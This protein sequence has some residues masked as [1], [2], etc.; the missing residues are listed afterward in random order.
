M[1]EIP[2]YS[3][4]KWVKGNSSF[5]QGFSDQY[6]AE[7]GRVIGSWAHIEQSF[8]VSMMVSVLIHKH[9]HAKEDGPEA[10]AIL[11]AGLKEQ[12]NLYRQFMREKKFTDERIKDGERLLSRIVNAREDRDA[13]AHW[14][15]TPDIGESF[16][17][18]TGQ[19]FYK[20]WKKIQN[21]EHKEVTIERLKEIF[22]KMHYLYW[23]LHDFVLGQPIRERPPLRAL[24]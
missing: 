12:A 4:G 8:I 19:G 16:P 24:R 6:L 1:L 15:L 22:G 20:S 11:G 13:V 21:A 18:D 3:N 10:R 9:P 7:L 5:M 2:L 14:P 23:D 17:S